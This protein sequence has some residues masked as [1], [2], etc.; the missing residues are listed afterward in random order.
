MSH[1][2]E[3]LFE[4]DLFTAPAKGDG[5]G[6]EPSGAEAD[7]KDA[8]AT[9]RCFAVQPQGAAR[10]DAHLSA[11]AYQRRWPEIPWPELVGTSVQHPHGVDD[12]GQPWRWLL[13]TKALPKARDGRAGLRPDGTLQP[14]AQGRYPIVPACFDCAISLDNVRPVMPR[15]ALAND[16][17][18]LREPFA[19]RRDGKKL[20][21]V[22]FM[23]LCL[24]RM[25][26]KKVIAE[27]ERRADPKTKQRGLRS[28]TIAFPQARVRELVTAALPAEPRASTEFIADTISIAM[29]GCNPMDLH[30][31]KEYQVPREAYLTAVRF[32]VR[33][34]EAY[35]N[36]RIDEAEAQ[37]RFAET[38][39]SCAEVLAQATAVAATEAA[40]LRLDGPGDAQ[41]PERPM[42]DGVVA[43]NG[44]PVDEGAADDPAPG[45]DGPALPT[46]DEDDLPDIGFRAMAS[47]LSSADLDTERAA[48]EFGA[49]V[50][51]VMQMTR[52]GVGEGERLSSV[53]SL[54]TLAAE[55]GSEEYQLRLEA[56][57]RRMDAAEGR[58]AAPPEA[59]AAA[60][61]RA[62]GTQVVH[63]GRRPLSMYDAE[64][65]QKSFPRL[66]PYGDGVFGL[67][68]RR[69][70]TFQQ[71]A[72]M[73]LLR[74]ELDYQV[75][76]AAS[77]PACPLARE[78]G[79]E[80]C[81]C[82]QCVNATAP[83]VQPAMPRWREDADFQCALYDTWRRMDLVRRAGAHVR[84]KGFRSSIKLVCGTTAADIARAFQELGDKAGVHEVLRSRKAPDT[85]K[86]AL[87]DVLLFSSEVVGS[88]GARQQLRHEQMGDM[89]RYGGIGG[90][91][92]PNVADTRSPI[93]VLLHADAL[94]GTQGGLTDDGEMERYA[95]NL[96]DECPDVPKADEMLRII[97]RDPVAQARFFIISMRLFC[98]HV[99]GTGP[100]DGSLRHHGRVD[101]VKFPDGYAASAMGG[102][103]NMIASLHGPIE[104]QARMSCH[105]HM[106]FQYVNRQSQAWLRSIL[107]RE[108][109][110][111]RTL[112]RGWQEKVLAAVAAI[113]VTS[114][115]TVPLHFVND[116][117]D[118]P[119]LRPMPYF[120]GWR[121]QD[122]FDGELE[123]DVEDPAKRRVDVPAVAP[124]VDHHLQAA[125][126]AAVDGSPA[127]SDRSVPLKGAVMSRLPHYRIMPE[128]RPTCD[129]HGCALRQRSLYDADGVDLRR[130]RESLEAVSEFTR[131]FATD[132]WEVSALSGYL[133][134]HHDTCFKYVE[135]VGRRRPQHCRF[136]F[137]HFV[138]LTL[139]RT[140]DSKGMELAKEYLVDRLLARVGKDL[141]LPWAPGDRPPS[142]FAEPVVAR[143]ELFRNAADGFRLLDTLGASV[144]TDDRQARRGRVKTVQFNPREGS[145]TLG[146][147]PCHR[148]NL[149]YQ[150]CRR[151]LADGFEPASSAR[152]EAD[153]LRRGASGVAARRAKDRP[154]K[155]LDFS[156][157]RCAAA[158]WRSGAAAA[159][160]EACRAAAPAGPGGCKILGGW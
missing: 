58:G 53:Q 113:Q 132:H 153:A 65:W 66:F 56:I 96:L 28:N 70:L 12:D 7:V 118:A 54:R 17:L 1:W 146:G 87:T 4:L 29:A 76:E 107:R 32:L 106:V 9:R 22:T 130:R 117:A 103:M 116:V 63:T 84:R 73:L 46:T 25:V 89:L 61:V 39:R 85:L 115:A 51:L 44:V 13:D 52:D 33:H 110:E 154:I 138:T 131:S 47:D 34:S 14:D 155:R 2:A 86:R 3:D 43:E 134:K 91:L 36:L 121:A 143:K 90:F 144:E 160:R 151:T 97:A 101:G 95:V 55:L 122:R 150:D 108:T 26:V 111:A 141:V 75:P 19:W 125:A 82:V 133:H 64:I 37:R 16:N 139:R 48:R 152:G 6:P 23:L 38:G 119:E 92:T 62:D 59:P 137:V 112:L 69:P 5:D 18:I 149:D 98:E 156:V 79:D 42:P 99:L 129:C 120:E 20:S 27:K 74:T 127:V 104:E 57:L 136:G 94:N 128:W 135:G 8:S 77:R 124:F 60:T 41:G 140:K 147:V 159:G 50:E 72:L 67:D 100:F 15:Y 126:A 105:S 30:D 35:Q 142:V 93:V 71:W 78:S 10:V 158:F 11:A 123:G 80:P 40:P 148:G 21:P 83:F 81:Q 145:T 102:T 49:K 109:E 45:L 114:V 31:A 68:R 24:A 88:D 157:Q